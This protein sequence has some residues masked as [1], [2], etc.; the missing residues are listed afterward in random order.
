MKLHKHI[1]AHIQKHQ[2]KYLFGL[3]TLFGIGII[4]VMV[5]IGVFWGITVLTQRC[6]G[7]AERVKMYEKAEV[8]HKVIYDIRDILDKI[9]TEW[10][11]HNMT[12]FE[13]FA[14]LHEDFH[15]AGNI[16][17]KFKIVKELQEFFDEKDR[18]L[19]EVWYFNSTKGK[20]QDEIYHQTIRIFDWMK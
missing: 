15:N 8:F 5:I 11:P 16:N 2:K 18:F 12:W 10:N 17:A 19:H 7:S 6:N 14:Q 13:Y 4:K 1:T 9:Q 20:I 3:W